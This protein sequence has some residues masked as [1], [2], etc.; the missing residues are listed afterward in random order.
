MG[1][2]NTEL[3]GPDLAE[4]IELNDLPEGKP[5]LAHARGE[6]L[7]CVRRKNE[8]F[9]TGATCTHYGGPLAEGL[10]VAE[11]ACCAN[12]QGVA[13]RCSFDTA[14]HEEGERC[15]SSFSEFPSPGVS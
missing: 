4:G 7:V 13:Y 12:G 11:S 15:S 5:L 14:G 8:V 1:A 6:A 10:I 2:Q 3:T 9:V